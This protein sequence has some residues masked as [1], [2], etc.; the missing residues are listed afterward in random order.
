MAKGTIYGT[1]VVN[2]EVISFVCHV[3]RKGMAVTV[4]SVHLFAD[5]GW[6]PI[7]DSGMLDNGVMSLA[8]QVGREGMSERAPSQQLFAGWSYLPNPSARTGYDTRS[9]FKRSLTGLNSQFSFS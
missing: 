2:K 4:P 1:S 8:V 5:N 7:Y 9:I 6:A 3:G